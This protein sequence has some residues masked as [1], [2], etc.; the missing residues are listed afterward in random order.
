MLYSKFDIEI[1]DFK[2]KK[3]EEAIDIKPATLFN[4]TF[5]DLPLE[6]NI[7]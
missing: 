3:T 4:F 1:E 2:L 7:L 6:S 5:E